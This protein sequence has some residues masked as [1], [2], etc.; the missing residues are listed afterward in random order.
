[1]ALRSFVKRCSA[2]EC[3]EAKVL[4][5]TSSPFRLRRLNIRNIRKFQSWCVS[6]K[7]LTHAVWWCM[8]TLRRP[9][10]RALSRILV[11]MT[12]A[13]VLKI[14]DTLMNSSSV[15]GDSCG[16]SIED[17]PFHMIL[18]QWLEKYYIQNAWLP[19]NSQRHI[20]QLIVENEHKMET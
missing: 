17:L 1:M 9:K 19:K 13:F 3:E 5:K 12:G 11:K 16:Q 10:T 6:E 20:E 14:A 15:S 7:W 18:D 2:L 8:K 4:Y